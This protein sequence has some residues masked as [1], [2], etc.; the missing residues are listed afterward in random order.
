MNLWL[1]S[2]LE[3]VRR[4]EHVLVGDVQVNLLQKHKLENITYSYE[5]YGFLSDCN[6]ICPDGSR[7]NLMCSRCECDGNNATGRVLSTKNIPIEGVSIS[8]VSSPYHPFTTSNE[9][10]SF[11]LVGSCINQRLLFTKE[12]FANHEETVPATLQFDDI[13]LLKIGR[14]TQYYVTSFKY[15]IHF[16]I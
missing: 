14:R 4:T 15:I 7:L 16:F 2:V 5:M 6:A 8:D 1:G 11:E 3:T 9:N 10:G 12:G 13:K